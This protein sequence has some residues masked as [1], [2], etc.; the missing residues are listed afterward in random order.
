MVRAN[1]KRMLMI[2][3]DSADVDYLQTHLDHLPCMRRLVDEGSLHRLE[4]PGE[5]M[6]AAV[7]PTFITGSDPGE[8]GFYYPMQFDAD[9]MRLLR[10]NPQWLPCEPFWNSLCRQGIPVTTFDVQTQFPTGVENS[11]EITNWG[12]QSFSQALTNQPHV[13]RAIMD[14]YGKHP[15]RHDVPQ[16]KTNNQRKAI[17]EATLA[18]IGHKR[19][20]SQWLMRETDWRLFITVFAECHRAGH[21][22]WPAGDGSEGDGQDLLDVYIELD[23]A[24]EQLVGQVDLD[25]TVVVIFSVHG[26]GPAYTQ[27]HFMPQIMDRVNATFAA[28]GRAGVTSEQKPP[29]RNLMRFLREALPPGLQGKIAEYA[30]ESVR[31]WV[32]SRQFAGGLDWADTPGFALPTGG[33]GFI[34]LNIKGREQPG[35]LE[36][37][38]DQHHDYREWVERCFLSLRD[39]E[40]GEPAV[41]AVHN[42]EVEFPGNRSARLPDLVA[43]WSNILPS[44][45]LTSDLLGTMESELLTGRN[46]LHRAEGFAIVCDRFSDNRPTRALS[47]IK[48]LSEFVNDIFVP[49]TGQVCQSIN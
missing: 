36:A 33:E 9:S 20:I 47:D 26:M 11:V 27:M 24:V 1:Q 14:K 16:S 10:V 48:H 32:V 41:K 13:L 35:V 49:E 5:V 30:P 31:D 6:S 25:D 18:G 12:S 17:K 28:P 3:L 8:H 2:G 19:E 15:M 46:G 39:G 4:S 23:S 21:Y 37:G 7:W 38:S 34:R 22:L 29:R 44:R 45:K 43:V 42:I 40:T